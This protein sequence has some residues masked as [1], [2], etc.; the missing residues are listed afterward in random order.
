MNLVLSEWDRLV[1]ELCFE[2]GKHTR[3]FVITLPFDAY[4]QRVSHNAFFYGTKKY[5]WSPTHM[6]Q[7][8]TPDEV[9]FLLYGPPTPLIRLKDQWELY[10]TIGFDRKTKKWIPKQ[11]AT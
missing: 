3:Y 8:I 4:R 10:E 7:V 5:N 6:Y 11:V 9:G 2:T 1:T